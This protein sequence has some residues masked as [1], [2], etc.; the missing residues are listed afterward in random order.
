VESRSVD[1]IDD[2]GGYRRPRREQ[3]PRPDGG[4]VGPIAPGRACEFPDFALSR[5]VVR[6]S[7]V[8]LR[9][10][11]RV[12]KVRIGPSAC[13][14]ALRMEIVEPLTSERVPHV[15]TQTR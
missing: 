9:G 14:P 6:R 15:A 5:S 8:P 1:V 4:S 2:S 3:R 13:M 7:S 10:V 12:E 11:M